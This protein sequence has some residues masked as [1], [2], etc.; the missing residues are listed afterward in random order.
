MNPAPPGS[1]TSNNHVIEGTNTVPVQAI[2]LRP[3]Q[4]ILYVQQQN[5][6]LATRSCI[7]D[8]PACH[9]VCPLH[10]HLPSFKSEAVKY[11]L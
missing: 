3:Q 8:C 7:A 1:T 10:L 6:P 11:P 9:T 4:E 2:A 5:L